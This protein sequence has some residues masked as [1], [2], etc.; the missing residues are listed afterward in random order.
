MSN[1]MF[2]LGILTFAIGCGQKNC[3]LIDAD[4]LA[5]P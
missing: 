1:E 3:F 2:F 5:F 4:K